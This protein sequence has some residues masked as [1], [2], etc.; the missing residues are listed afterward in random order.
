MRYILIPLFVV[1]T[2]LQAAANQWSAPPIPVEYDHPY[3]G[4]LSVLRFPPSEV[5]FHC[6]GKPEDFN[7]FGRGRV[8]ACAFFM[9]K[10]RCHVNLP[11]DGVYT[12]RE[13]RYIERHEIAHC[14][15]WRHE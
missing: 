9:S 6:G 14:N 8:I 4:E 5:H 13:M 12:E 1:T 11:V 3:Y 15:G 10:T 2:F 7:T